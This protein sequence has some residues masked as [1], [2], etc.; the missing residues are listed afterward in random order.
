VTQAPFDL[1]AALAGPL[2][3]ALTIAVAY[4]ATVDWTHGG[5]THTPEDQ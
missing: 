4:L 3:A 1:P 2:I 5:R